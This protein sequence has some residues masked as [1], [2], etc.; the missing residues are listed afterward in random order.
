MGDI[1]AYIFMGIVMTV[2]SFYV[3]EFGIVF[4]REFIKEDKDDT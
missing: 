4:Y 3:I 1:I 2:I